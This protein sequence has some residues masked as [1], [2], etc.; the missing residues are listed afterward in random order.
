MFLT[1]VAATIR[2][3]RVHD[4]CQ[5]APNLT[6][7]M[8]WEM[9][10]KQTVRYFVYTA[11]FLLVGHDLLDLPTVLNNFIWALLLYKVNSQYAQESCVHSSSTVLSLQ[12]L[13]LGKNVKV[14]VT[15]QIEAIQLK[16]ATYGMNT[17]EHIRRLLPPDLSTPRF[18]ALRF[19]RCYHCEPPQTSTPCIWRAR[20]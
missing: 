1:P 15:C 10:H 16:C 13:R 19:K 8:S 11:T 4:W 5:R 9:G 14:I 2:S 20:V 6:C 7:L 18:P 3:E 12:E 17:K